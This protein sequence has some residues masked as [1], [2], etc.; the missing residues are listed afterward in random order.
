MPGGNFVRRGVLMIVRI[1]FFLL[2]ALYFTPNFAAAED[3]T[4]KTS[5][6][7]EQILTKVKDGDSIIIETGEYYGNLL[8]DKSIT[9]RGKENATIQGDSEGYVL[10]INADNVTIENLVIRGGGSHNAGIYISSNHNLIKHN[11]IEDVFHGVYIVEGYGNSIIE[12]RITSFS[13]RS[14]HKGFGVYLV[15]APYSTI[16]NNELYDL[17][18]GIYVSYSDFCEVHSNN[19]LR[20]RYG[21]HTMDSKNVVI[22][23][24]EVSQSHNGLM[25][26]QSYEVHILGNTFHSNTTIDGSGM[27]IF[28]TFDSV[29]STNTMKDNFRGIYLE[30]AK[31]NIIHFNVFLENDI[32]LELGTASETNLIYLNNFRKNTTQVISVPGNKN[33]FS[34]DQ[35]GNYW[36]DQKIVNLNNDDII[37]FAYK[38]GDVFYHLSKKEPLLQIFQQSPAVRLWNSIEKYTPVPSEQFIIDK[39]PLVKPA[40]IQVEKANSLVTPAHTKWQIEVNKLLFFTIFFSIGIITFSISRRERLQ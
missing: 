29:I 12:N 17:Q 35:Y 1:C 32:G 39:H 7:L 5:E 6:E 40:P 31:R 16:K 21:V 11:T 30:N 9:I 27:F 2:F 33:L 26:M 14:D 36:D 34:R 18:D 22:A 23:N 15:D 37:D 13:K 28:D 8:I 19:I 24:N 38:S 25:I 4:I 10:S 3:Y 20:A